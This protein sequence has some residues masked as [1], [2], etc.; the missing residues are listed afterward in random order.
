MVDMGRWLVEHGRM[1]V[2]RVGI[3]SREVESYCHSCQ[4]S[5]HSFGHRTRYIQREID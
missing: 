3:G 1:V 4:K 5:G 2:G